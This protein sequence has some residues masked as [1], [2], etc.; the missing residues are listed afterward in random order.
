[1]ANLDKPY[2]VTGPQ[3]AYE[4]H[5]WLTPLENLAT[6]QVYAEDVPA[7]RRV[8]GE[9]CSVFE[10]PPTTAQVR[11]AR[12]AIILDLTLE[13][14]RY[15]R[16]R[17]IDGLAF[18]ASEDLCLDLIER[19]RGETSPAEA[20]AILIARRDSL[21]WDLLL[22]QAQRR[23]LTRPLGALLEAI[24]T[25]MGTDITPVGFI[26]QL[27]RLAEAERVLAGGKGYPPGRHQAASSE[28]TSLAERW[29][30]RWLLPRYVI[31]KVVFDLSPHSRQALEPQ[32]G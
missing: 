1:L 20:A 7:W 16:R 3:A 19:A 5:H 13:P 30:I 25:E 31:S 22:D 6:I 14:E 9:G 15:G 26:R 17:V 4:Y 24:N 32:R 10:A 18:V 12:E 27:H 23:G 21:D 29:G 2:L 11:A 28:Y 8:A